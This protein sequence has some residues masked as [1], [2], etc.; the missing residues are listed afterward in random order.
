MGMA[1]KRIDGRRGEGRK[2]EVLLSKEWEIEADLVLVLHL[3]NPLSRPYFIR[4]LS[5]KGNELEKI[6]DQSL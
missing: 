6:L 4:P 3:G 2:R 5:L 1:K